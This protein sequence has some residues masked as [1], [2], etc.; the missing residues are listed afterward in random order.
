MRHPQAVEKATKQ[1]RK[2]IERTKVIQFFFASQLASLISY[3]HANGVSLV[4]DIPIFVAVD[5]VDVWTNR[6]LFKLDAEGKTRRR[7]AVFRRMRSPLMG[8][9]WGTRCTIGRSMRRPIS[10]GGRPG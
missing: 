1:Y 7:P 8:Q 4:G 3:A 2:E 10:L 9:L 6:S 5:S